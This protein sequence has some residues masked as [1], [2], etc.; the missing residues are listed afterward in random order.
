[1]RLDVSISQPGGPWSMREFESACLRY[2]FQIIKKR[3]KERG[4]GGGYEI[5]TY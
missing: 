1:M 5:F 2:K 4:G 3:I